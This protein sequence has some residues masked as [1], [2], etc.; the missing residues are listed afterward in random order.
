MDK[1]QKKILYSIPGWE[2]FLSEY[3]E[4]KNFLPF[5]EARKY[6][7]NLKLNGSATWQ[8]WC[9]SG[10]KPN[11]IPATP[12]AIYKDCGWVSWGNW[13]G[14]GNINKKEFRSFDESRKFVRNL[15]LSGQRAFREWSKSGKRPDDIPSNPHKIYKNS[16][17]V[18]YGDFLGTSNISPINRNFLSFKEAREFVLDLKLK[19]NS[20]WQKWSRSSDRPDNIPSSPNV[21]YKDSG[22]ISWGNFLGTNNISPINRKFLPF[23]EARKFARN[24]KLNSSTEWREWSKS[25]NRPD[26]I[27][28]SP[29]TTYKD[30]GWVGWGDF[31]GTSNISPINRNFLPFK[32]AREFVRK[33]KLNSSKAWREWSKS[34]KRP[35]NIPSSPDRTYKNS[36]WIGMVDWLG[37]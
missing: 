23:K 33:L 37:N 32:E 16:G 4:Y 24:L 26:D 12:N 3:I 20:A 29:N 30:S 36:G 1:S 18:G 22:W 19:N 34:D 35:D 13:L 11:N 21:F 5:K 9:K 27:P 2:E 31:L 7:R 15:K 25:G 6:A 14:T 8:K 17:W 28:S 10:E